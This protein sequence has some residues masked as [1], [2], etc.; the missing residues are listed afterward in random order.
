MLV[1]VLAIS[2]HYP[3]VVAAPFRGR[4]ERELT[5]VRRV[6]R[7][8]VAAVY[9]QAAKPRSVDRRHEEARALPREPQRLR[10]RS[11]SGVRLLA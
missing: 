10:R 1:L 4:E 11:D 3:D 6:D 7:E 9:R 5:A 8:P 2:V